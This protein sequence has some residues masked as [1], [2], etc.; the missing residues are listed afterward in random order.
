MSQETITVRSN[1]ILSLQKGMS[2][3]LQTKAFLGL[4]QSENANETYRMVMT[5]YHLLTNKP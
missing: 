1:Y 3:N 4:S 2:H 5:G